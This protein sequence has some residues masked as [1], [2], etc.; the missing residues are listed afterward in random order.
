MSALPKQQQLLVALTMTQ[1]G[2]WYV[3]VCMFM[4]IDCAYAYVRTCRLLCLEDVYA[5]TI[6]LSVCACACVRLCGCLR[7]S[8]RDSA[9]SFGWWV[10]RS[11]LFAVMTSKH[12]FLFVSYDHVVTS[13]LDPGIRVAVPCA[14]LDAMELFIAFSD[15]FLVMSRALL[16]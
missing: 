1:R 7:V 5:V 2:P 6:S 13:P 12:L 11:L 15:S 16:L 4:H 10:H 8:T 3:F 14:S 9:L